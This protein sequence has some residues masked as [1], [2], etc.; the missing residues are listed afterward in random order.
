M[1]H[2]QCCAWLCRANGTWSV[3][4]GRPKGL[5][6]PSHERMASEYAVGAGPRPARL[7]HSD[8]SV[9]GGTPGR[10]KCGP[11]SVRPLRKARRVP[12]HFAGAAI[13]SPQA[14]KS[15]LHLP[16]R[17]IYGIL[18]CTVFPAQRQRGWERRSVFCYGQGH[19]LR[20][21]RNSGELPHP[22]HPRLRPGGPPHPARQGDQAL[23][24]HR[25]AP[26]HAPECGGTVLLRRGGH[27]QRPVLYGGGTGAPQQPHAPRGGGGGGR[28]SM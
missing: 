5:P 20:R 28:T 18:I 23:S 4:D 14:A 24:V 11:A 21:G 16:Q 25:A 22:H 1:V 7:G 27:P 9:G 8:V 15:P 13:R 2:F 26:G 17:I 3:A 12:P 6:Y 19:F 10:P